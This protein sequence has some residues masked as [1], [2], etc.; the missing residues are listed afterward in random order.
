MGS[1]TSATQAGGWW[2][3]MHQQ[4]FISHSHQLFTPDTDQVECLRTLGDEKVYNQRF[5]T[6]KESLQQLITENTTKGKA[7]IYIIR[8]LNTLSRLLISEQGLRFII[9]GHKISSRF[10]KVVTAFG[11]R[12]HDE[13]RAWDGYQISHPG[14]EVTEL[15]YVV[16]YVERHNRSPQNPWSVRQI[17]VYQQVRRY[18]EDETWIILQPS[19][20]VYLRVKN[21]LENGSPTR[22]TDEKSCFMHLEILELVAGG[23]GDYIEWAWAEVDKLDDKACISELGFDKKNDYIV[24]FQDCQKLQRLRR[25]LLRALSVLDSN[26]ALTSGIA[27]RFP[28]VSTTRIANHKAEIDLHRRNLLLMLEH[29]KGTSDLL[30]NILSTRNDKTVLSGTQAMQESLG[31]M[32]RIAQQGRDDSTILKLLSLIA[33]VYLPA[34][35]VALTLNDKTIFS[36]NLVALREDVNGSSVFHPVSQFWLYIVLTISLT[37][38]TFISVAF[39]LRRRIVE[40][41]RRRWS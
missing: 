7:S 31:L 18:N 40:D 39:V 38:L 4:H 9:E 20:N 22:N 29:L 6:E 3:D 19:E 36:S 11:T 13:N 16:R 8:Q 34:S 2:P 17:G 37:L 21:I 5:T 25:R 30:F 32:G 28:D 12:R 15:S 1:P 14:P 10:L 33:T 41:I 26:I 23:W 27:A 24:T 35:L